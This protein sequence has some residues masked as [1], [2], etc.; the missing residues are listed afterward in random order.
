VDTETRRNQ[1]INATLRI[2]AEKGIVH[3]KTA[4][5]AREVGVSEG[6]IF[7]HFRSKEEIVRAVQDYIR[8]TL[9]GGAHAVLK[10]AGPGP[11]EKIGAL[12]RFQLSLIEENPGIPRLFFSGE[13]LAD[14][15]DLKELMGKTVHDF[16]EIPGEIFR[17]AKEEG[18]L[19]EE[20]DLEMAAEAYLGVVQV[21]MLRW[22]LA[23]RNF[24]LISR[25]ERIYNF[26]TLC[27]FC[28]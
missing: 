28:S 11:R 19:R 6:A 15:G 10:K 9:L 26:L 22:M 5:I 3:F 18:I 8:E 13:S 17:Q 20:V 7:R 27:L 23:G 24:S 21:A 2:I 16:L 25:Y 12:L 4:E 14:R 1:I